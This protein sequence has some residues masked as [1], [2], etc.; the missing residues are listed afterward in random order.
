MK[1]A[2]YCLNMIETSGY[3]VK[4][5]TDYSKIPQILDSLGKPYVTPHLSPNRNDFT[6]ASSFW[7]VVEKDGV[8]VAAGGV[9]LEDLG[10]ES[11]GQYW[12]RLYKRQSGYGVR[13]IANPLLNELSGKLA[14]LGD[15]HLKEGHRGGRLLLHHCAILCH[16]IVSI[17]W[18]P[19]W[20]YAFLHKK[21]V[22]RGAAALYGF[23]RTI[24]QS[25]IWQRVEQPRRDDEYC[26]SL[27]RDEYIHLIDTFGFD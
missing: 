23:S 25:K 10:Q 11:V 20:T 5:Y 13:R 26:A 27:S 6:Q 3:S 22:M 1:V 4:E 7:I 14:Y 2:A 24:P 17:K 8:V 18:S 21:D 16:V 9:R 19:D 12:D 15:L